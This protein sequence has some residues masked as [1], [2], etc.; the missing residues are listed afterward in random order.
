L[1]NPSEVLVRR[2]FGSAGVLSLLLALG[3]APKIVHAQGGVDGTFQ[4]TLTVAGPVQLEVSTGSGHIDVKPG[5][6]GRVEVRS[7]FR[8]SER[9]RLRQEAE[10]IARQLESNPPIE[11]TGNVIR[12]GHI[13]DSDARRNVTINYMVT[14]PA[15]T[16]L[17]SRTG[18]GNQTIA[19]LA[20]PV[21]AS[22]GSGDI[23][24]DNIGDAFRGSTGSGSIRM[25]Q[26]SPG[27][28]EVSTGSG[29]VD[30]HAIK[31][32]LRVRTGSGGVTVD[33]EATGPWDLQTG[34]GSINIRLPEQ[35]AFTVDA[36]T[37]SGRIT[38]DHPLTITGTV[39][40]SE[41]RGTVRGGGVAL[42]ARTGSGSIRIQ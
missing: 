12:I 42:N 9:G 29:S 8:V 6:S 35:A 32:S 18:S 34:A 31:G 2:R 37:G 40:R 24:A 28:V 5:S 15:D 11:Q 33:G 26:T 10:N 23:A 25:S 22:T 7:M 13:D 3:C 19:G 38:V 4:R 16:Q 36:H 27:S 41:V 21:D 17:R 30:L 39:R 1:I 14:V 20:G